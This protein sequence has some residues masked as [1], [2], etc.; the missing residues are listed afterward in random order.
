MSDGSA[1]TMR[2]NFLLI[3]TAQQ[4]ADHLSCYGNCVLKTPH[5]DRI[6]DQ[7]ATFEEC[8]TATPGCMPNR[9]SLM[10]GRMPSLHGVRHDGIALDQRNRT[11][12]DVLAQHGYR[13][14]LVG[15]AN[16]Q[17]M[18]GAAQPS[19]A[20]EGGLEAARRDGRY[21]QERVSLWESDHDHE[22]DLPYYGFHDVALVS[23]HGD[24]ASGH[25]RKW[26]S[27][28]HPRPEA[29]RGP[30]NALGNPTFTVPQAWRTAMP[31]ELYPTTYVGEQTL[32]RLQRFAREPHQP[33]FLKCSFPDPHHPFTPPGYYWG[34]YQPTD[35]E[36]PACWHMTEPTSMPPHLRWLHEQLDER[37]ANRT[38]STPFACTVREAQEAVALTYGMITMIDDAVG[39]ILDRLEQL[40]LAQNTVVIFTSDHGD[41]MG[42]HGLL[43]RGPLHYNGLIRTPLI[44]REPDVHTKRR[45]RG[46][47]STVDIAATI[48]DRAGLR[49]FNGM[50]G[51]SLMPLMNDDGDG[52]EC[53]LIEDEAHGPDIGLE[54][55]IKLR[56]LVDGRFRMSL[57]CGQDWGELYDLHDDPEEQINRWDDP[58]YTG[59]RGHLTEL[60]AEE[61]IRSSETSPI[62]DN[63]EDNSEAIM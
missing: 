59:I 61:M 30:R 52:R 48:I 4:R 10:T 35:V 26:L 31:E 57:Y 33:F 21:D 32:R 56:T 19:R 39:R 20:P 60:L 7:G 37:H 36:T 22:L 63:S 53:V 28:R 11:F 27:D 1:G 41:F 47:A 2:P 58:S 40:G 45:I 34:L 18:F 49:G 50:Q 14:A 54:G 13:T 23:D 16:F 12:A 44:W 24:Q 5:I 6:A 43:L 46:L 42:D 38:S 17:N 25:F 9:A 8:Y 51:R 29:L 15:K 62:V 3:M 55:H